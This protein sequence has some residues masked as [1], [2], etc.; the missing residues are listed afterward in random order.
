MNDIISVADILSTMTVCELRLL[1]IRAR[2]QP[3]MQIAV[4][5]HKGYWA[6]P[7]QILIKKIAPFFII[8]ENLGAPYLARIVEDYHIL[9]E[10]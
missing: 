4:D 8:K 1:V 10:L 2:L 6:V 9:L 3:Y 5:G 7:K